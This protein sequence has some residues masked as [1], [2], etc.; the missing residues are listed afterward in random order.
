[1]A[2]GRIEYGK[3]RV[4]DQVE[5]LGFKRSR[6]TSVRGIEMF[7][8]TYEEATAGDSVGL[9]LDGIAP[10]DLERGMV[11]AIPNTI[12]PHIRFEA[13]AYVLTREE[14][15]RHAPLFLGHRAQFNVQNAEVT[16]QI[17]SFTANG[18]PEDI[19]L[20]GDHRTMRA[21]LLRPVALQ[22]GTRMVLSDCGQTVGAA[23]VT[24]VL[25]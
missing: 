8:K 10:T 19:V 3:V 18:V 17:T 4:G 6:E 11:V 13:E 23:V 15:G 5:I 20:P 12:K 14:G 2:Q 7:G 16:G 9:L 24:D 1:M 22:R 21:Q 25:A